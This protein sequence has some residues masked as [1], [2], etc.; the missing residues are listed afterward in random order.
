MAQ[1]YVSLGSNIDPQRHIPQ[2]LYQM[3]QRFGELVVSTV[4][5]NEPIGF[6]GNPFWNLV[7]GF[8]TDMAPKTLADWLH[9]LEERA[10]RI[11]GDEKFAARTL[12]ADLLL[13]DDLVI[14]QGGLTLPRDEIV[15]YPFVLRPLAE[16]APHVVH[17]TRG[18]ALGVIWEAFGDKQ[19]NPLRPV[20]L[21]TDLSK[22]SK[23]S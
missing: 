16:I 13:Y 15:K 4:Y 20:D 9:R 10:G 14:N 2:C 11:R 12:D 19:I 18:Q 1:V 8:Q 3:Q 6:D 17:P 22:A 23:S 5:E 7:V 21:D